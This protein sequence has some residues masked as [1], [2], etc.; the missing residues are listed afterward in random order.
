MKH[1]NKGFD[2]NKLNI[3]LLVGTLITAILTGLAVEL[4]YSG[5]ANQHTDSRVFMPIAMGILF[6]G[7]L[8]VI[9][10]VV[11][12]ISKMKLTFKADVI[13]GRN[14]NRI[15]VYLL[16]GFLVISM[17]MFG[18]EYL[19]EHTFR[20]NTKLGSAADTYVFLIDNS[21][22]M[23]TNDPNTQ[24]YTAI[25]EIMETKPGDTQFTVYSFA[26]TAQQLVPMRTVSSGFPEYPKTDEIL[27][28][29]RTGL[30]KVVTDCENGVWTAG[31]NISL[32]MITD[33]AP[34]DFT[35][36]FE[37][38]SILD[39]CIAQNMTLSIV[40]VIGANNSLMRQMASYTGGTFTDINDPLLIGEAIL[41]VTENAYR[42]RDL[43]SLRNR[44]AMDWLY[45]LIRIVSITL[46][47]IIIAIAAGMAYGNNTA[48]NFIVGANVAKAL[49]AGLLLEF[50]NQI[51]VDDRAVRLLVLI[52]LG[53][54]I[55]RNG[56]QDNYGSRDSYDM[57]LFNDLGKD[58]YSFRT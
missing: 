11:F 52:L 58:T 10:F 46:A 53:T 47:G 54:I 13:T 16:L 15:L 9:A 23:L 44:V 27:T 5:L 33:G 1:K 25:N 55:S 12:L 19:Y 2:P 18:A 36:F 38:S 29:M 37:V 35:F 56:R 26:D 17:L 34:T 24:R 57:D 42:T 30:E 8:A 31:G 50:G 7:F 21:A 49:V 48:F 20:P 51:M 3:A 41:S 40:G 6:A 4:F 32:I 28:E 14:H 45:A 39:R 43:L 22:S